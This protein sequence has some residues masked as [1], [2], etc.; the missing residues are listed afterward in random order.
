MAGCV[1]CVYYATHEESILICLLFV[2]ASLRI[3]VLFLSFSR[4]PF[5]L[6]YCIVFY[7]FLI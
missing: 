6:L 5:L 1:Y 4:C 7:S 3:A 2:I